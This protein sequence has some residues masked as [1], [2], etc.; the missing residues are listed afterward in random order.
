MN[1]NTSVG[2][3]NRLVLVTTDLVDLHLDY[4]TIETGDS[5]T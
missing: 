2:A 1:P 4:G 5:V 3:G